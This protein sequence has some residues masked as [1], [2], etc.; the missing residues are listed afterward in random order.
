M[1]RGTLDDLAAFAAVARH[2]SFTRAAAEMG[3]SASALSHT[4]RALEERYG[5]RLLARTT[6]SVAPTPAGERLLRSV[7]PA[8]DE[9]ARGLDALADWRGEPS[10]SLRL[11]TFPYAARTILEPRLPRFLIDHPAVSVE[12][13]VDDRLTDIVAAGFDAGIRF[14][15]T[16]ERDMVAVRVGPDLRT[17][18][19]GTP[20]YFARHPRP[21]TPADLEAHR[22]VNYRLVGGGGLLP[23]E[24]ARDGR[25]VRVRASGQLIAN[26]GNLA[27]A[28]VRAAAG[29]GYMLEDEVADDIAAG[30]LVQVLDSWC[31][32]FPGCHLYYPDRQVSPAMRSLIEALRWRDGATR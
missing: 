13:I 14:G 20:D 17:V 12:V 3:L 11:T 6:R 18:V 26:D 16:V 22:C 8:L 30:R 5:V 24:F 9:V 28:A 27:A 25:E 2:R 31:P 23:W 4:V 7:A 21:D 19:V 32:P 1:R 15:E 29:L 10:G